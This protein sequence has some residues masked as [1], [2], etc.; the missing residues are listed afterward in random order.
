M[1][2]ESERGFGVVDREEE[3]IMIEGVENVVLMVEGAQEQPV[4][5][6]QFA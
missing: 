5:R 6:D 2:G 3:D 1:R 4:S